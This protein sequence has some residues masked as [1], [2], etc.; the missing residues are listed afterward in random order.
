MHGVYCAV[1]PGYING[2][3]GRYLI[4]IVLREEKKIGRS[5]VLTVKAQRSTDEIEKRLKFARSILRFDPKTESRYRDK[6]VDYIDIALQSSA[7]GD[8]RRA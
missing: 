2:G 8:S 5:L 1:D 4:S 7:G 6:G 3:L